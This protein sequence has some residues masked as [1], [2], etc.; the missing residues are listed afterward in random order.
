MP[1][2]LLMALDGGFWVFHT[3]LIFF[4]ILGWAWKRTRRWNLLTLGLTMASWLLMGLWKG[5]GY[6]ICTDWHFK[7]RGAL[8]IHDNAD[9]Y[10]QLL[11]G[12]LSGWEAPIGLLNACA[13][14][15]LGLSVVLSVTL[16][17]ID[18]RRSKALALAPSD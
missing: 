8:G 12:K 14:I 18:W 6:C 16:N 11:V 1:Y 13:G 9:S 2:W 15:F 3:L 7:V 17:I 4:N 5:I 10:L